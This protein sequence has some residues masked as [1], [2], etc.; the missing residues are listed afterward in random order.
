MGWI[1]IYGSTPEGIV[2]SKTRASQ[3][4]YKTGFWYDSSYYTM[5]VKASIVTTTTEYRGM[6]EEKAN[7]V[8]NDLDSVTRDVYSVDWAP[9][10]GIYHYGSFEVETSTT[11]EVRRA[12]E[13]D[14]YSVIVVSQSYELNHSETSG[15]ATVTKRT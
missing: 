4:V 5:V 10:T 15:T 1:D 7:A 3:V 14:G 6:T 2:T 13:A 12:N 11:A 8:A 9:G